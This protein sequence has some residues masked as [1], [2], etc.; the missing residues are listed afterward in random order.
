MDKDRDFDMNGR[1]TTLAQTEA[2]LSSATS[3]AASEK[4]S[5][6][7]PAVIIVGP[8]WPRSGTARVIQN[9]IQYYRRRGFFTVFIA[10]PFFWYYIHLSKNPK[11]MMEGMDEL[12]ADR[13]FATTLQQK[14]YN[15]AKYKA[16]LRHAFR[17]TALD[18]QVAIGKSAILDKKDFELL[19]GL[20]TTVF[21]V[22]HV[23]TLG[24]ALDLRRQLFGRSGPPTILETHDVQSHL[25]DEKKELNPWTHRPDTLKRLLKSEVTLLKKADVLVH[26]SVDDFQLLH[27]LLP[28]K[29]H[30]LAFPTIDENFT[31]AVSAQ[32][33][34]AEN[35]DLLFVGQQ[36][37]ANF[38]AVKWF[39]EQVWP[40]IS[41]RGYNLKIV[42]PIGPKVQRELPQLYEA[43]RSQFV[44][45]VAD[46][47]PYYRAARCVIAPMVSGSGISVKTIEA[48]AL[49]K[50]FVG[51]TKA[52]RGMPMERLKA[53]GIRACDEPQ[54]FADAIVHALCNEQEAQTL[55]RA[56]YDSIFSPQ[57]SSAARDEALRAATVLGQPVPFMRHLGFL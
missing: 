19:R 25:L 27:G 13:I 2:Q 21:H 36:H 9:E 54:A 6:D 31:R 23:Y 47:I 7:A 29:S 22:N 24:F 57:A 16:S 33:P 18:W 11:E 53:L 44:G 38:A 55:S 28:S 5:S 15:A 56:A 40:S 37:P 17:G 8:P 1:V 32:I 3:G 12:G 34:P 49:G 52:F 41:D 45:P 20:R 14:S 48:W 35:I 50:A 46:L 43:F 26:L 51:T 30:F 4:T 42:G 10:V 39:L